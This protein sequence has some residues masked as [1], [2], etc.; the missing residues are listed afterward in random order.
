MSTIALKGR[1]F[2]ETKNKVSVRERIAEYFKTVYAEYA[3][4]IVC[5]MLAVTG[6]RNVFQ[7]YQMMKESGR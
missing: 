7:V 3:P 1:S 2:T 5:G 4:E 6:S